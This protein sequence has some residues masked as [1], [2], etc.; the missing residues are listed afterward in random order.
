MTSLSLDSIHSALVSLH[1]SLWEWASSVC[2]AALLRRSVVSDSLGPHMD[3]S[4][5]RLRCPWDFP[6][7]NTGVGRHVLLQGI[8]PTQG[9][10][11][12]LLRL[13]HWQA[14]SFTT[15]PPGKPQVCG[16]KAVICRILL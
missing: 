8:F 14:D 7:K 16:R 15:V 9:W 5:L 13:L 3:C 1:A 11:P 6:G 12:C 4:P 2:P 10:S